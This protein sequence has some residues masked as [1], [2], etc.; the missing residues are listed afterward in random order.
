MMHLLSDATEAYFSGD[1]FHQPLQL[2]R[3]EI[4]FGDCDDVEQ[5]IASRRRL[6]ETCAGS[7]A[8]IIPAHLSAPHCI[9]VS[10]DAGEFV[11]QA[12]MN[13]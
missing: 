6:V 10:R 2:V 8:L 11:F 4:Q 7:G 9:R 13:L 12:G 1:V 5:A 3:P